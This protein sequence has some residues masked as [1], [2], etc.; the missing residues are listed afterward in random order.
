M[1]I[2]PSAGSDTYRAAAPPEAV[3]PGLGERGQVLKRYPKDMPVEY[4]SN[5]LEPDY[6]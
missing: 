5:T 4:H 6:V 3:L 1:Q 2:T